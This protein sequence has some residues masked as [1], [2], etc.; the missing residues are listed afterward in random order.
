MPKP[1][2][3]NIPEDKR[4]R[5]RQVAINAFTH[6]PFEQI[7]VNTIIKEAKISRGSFYTYFDDLDSLFNY[8]LSDL[9]EE[10]FRYA[11][12][13]IKTCKGDFFSFIKSLFAYDFDNYR[14]SGRYSL[15]RNYIHY[16]QSVKKGTIKD[17]MLSHAFASMIKNNSIQTYF[18]LDTLNL[19]LDMFLDLVE[20]VLI[21]MINTFI[22]AENENLSK[23]DAI[24]LFNQRMRFIEF[25]VKK[26]I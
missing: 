13:I 26:Q 2:F 9:I 11:T 20:I 4:N 14:Q 22:K 25:G 8:I 10:R 6:H 19:D 3:Y 16:V 7:S 17:A 24:S 23:Q 1:M 12:K 18:N 15:F 21:L 5:I